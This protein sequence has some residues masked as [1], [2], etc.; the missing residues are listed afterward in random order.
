MAEVE[1]TLAETIDA[2]IADYVQG[3]HDERSEEDWQELEAMGLCDGS[4]DD[5]KAGVFRFE[6]D[7]LR[8]IMADGLR[9]QV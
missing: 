2:M 5:L 1:A 4:R 8:T 9:K 3:N 7:L 6:R